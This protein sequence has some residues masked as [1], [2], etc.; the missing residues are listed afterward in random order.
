MCNGTSMYVYMFI[1]MYKYSYTYVY[2]LLK[3]RALSMLTLAL[4]L[5]MPCVP[6]ACVNCLTA[7]EY[8]AHEEQKCVLCSSGSLAVQSRYQQ[9]Q[10]LT[11]TACY[12][13]PSCHSCGE[14]N[15]KVSVVSSIM[16]TDCI[17]KNSVLLIEDHTSHSDL[18]SEDFI[19]ESMW[20]EKENSPTH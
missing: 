13:W 14:R 3:F 10:F 9:I 17:H 15:S 2:N 1:C 12:R 20:G 6:S 4:S 8:M 11:K 5:K 16:G 18:H 19:F 7:G